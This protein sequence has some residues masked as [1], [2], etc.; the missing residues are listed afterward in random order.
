MLL[1]KTIFIVGAGASTDYG[2]PV[3]QTLSK[4]IA[5]L[6]RHIPDPSRRAR[7]AL[8]EAIDC[9][10]HQTKRPASDLFRKAKEI[11]SALPQAPSVDAYIE[12]M[13]HDSDI[14]VLGKLGIAAC[15]LDT[16]RGCPLFVDQRKDLDSLD[17][18]RLSDTWLGK[19]FR[20][21]VEGHT[22]K[23]FGNM[24]ES[25]AFVVFNYDRCIEQYFKYAISNYFRVPLSKSYEV[26]RRMRLVRP[27]GSLGQL[28]DEHGSTF[29]GNGPR[30]TVHAEQ[31]LTIAKDIR[32]YS[33]YIDDDVEI[34]QARSLLYQAK[35]TVYLGFA[36]HRQNVKLLEKIMPKGRN[37]TLAT[38][39]GIPEPAHSIVRQDIARIVGQRSASASPLTLAA[40]EC[41]PF[42]DDYRLL[43]SHR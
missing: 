37:L 10:A 22:I 8:Q 12:N 7:G 30:G 18:S 26:V 15:L 39:L 35:A 20:I 6:L 19:L 14:A 29:G 4:N 34:E 25:A 43:L 2:L 16:E 31:L 27:Y 36:F 9:H 3:G 17:H 23:T 24:F 1:Y 5:T 13:A 40:S 32:T 41:A 28:V 33:E 11:A 38:V 21:L 42:I